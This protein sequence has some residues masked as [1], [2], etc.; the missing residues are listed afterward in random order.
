MLWFNF[1]FGLTISVF[2]FGVWY[3]MYPTSRVFSL[4][5]LLKFTKSFASPVIRIVGLFYTGQPLSNKPTARPISDSNDFV[6]AKSHAR[7]KPL[8]VGFYVW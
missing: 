5:L 1:V 8:L 6:N 4:A 7:E 2:W 3:C